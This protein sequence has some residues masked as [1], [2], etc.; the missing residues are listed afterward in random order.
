[1]NTSR[2]I[3]FNASKSSDK[4]VLNRYKW[5]KKRLH[6]WRTIYSKWI[7]T[8]G[9][10]LKTLL[11]YGQLIQYYQAH[12]I[13]QEPKI[14]TKLFKHSDI[15]PLL[16]EYKNSFDIELDSIGASFEGKSIYK[17]TL[18][19]GKRP[20]LFWSQMH[21]DEATATLALLDLIRFLG[22]KEPDS[23]SRLRQLI[24][25]QLSIHII[26]MLNP[27]GAE[28][29]KRRNAQDVDINRDAIN[30]ESPEARIL[31]KVAKDI[32]PVF[33]FNLHDQSP[34]YTVGESS[35]QTRLAFLAPAYREPK[36]SLN[37]NRAN[38][39]RLIA[40]LNRQLQTIIPGEVARFADDY[41]PRAFGD[42]FQSM[43]I[44]TVLFE[45]GS[46]I[47]DSCKMYNRKL[48]FGLFVELLDLIARKQ[49]LYEGLQGYFDIPANKRNAYDILLKNITVNRKNKSI[50]T[51]IALN[52]VDFLYDNHRKT[53]YNYM[54]V[55]TGPMKGKV[56]FLEI[57]FENLPFTPGKIL[58]DPRLWDI[59]LPE[60]FSKGYTAIQVGQWNHLVKLIQ[61][62]IP[63]TILYQQKP[64]QRN[65]LINRP[66]DVFF[67]SDSKAL[68]LV[69][70][71]MYLQEEF[72]EAL[73]NQT[74]NQIISSF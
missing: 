35:V 42:L 70:G 43:G 30:L 6:Q 39:M 65:L 9:F 54:V 51:H 52:R 38:A 16:K 31:L 61:A 59:P 41:E 13:Y 10:L 25:D 57:D 2:K 53:H 55:D 29:F 8:L 12:P 20:I 58:N 48:H 34:Y 62:G 3:I 5:G 50:K 56:A 68:V 23:F 1:M 72:K 67:T 27:D 45:S 14:Q 74:L 18:G 11:M 60:L 21:G 71:K 44:S 15:L 66:F 49:Y 64:V 22:I 37:D 47:D 69:N 33:G 28:V 17:I 19:Q 26:P 46:C 36:D 7:F 73:P 32:Q 24:L 63:M 40:A 4:L